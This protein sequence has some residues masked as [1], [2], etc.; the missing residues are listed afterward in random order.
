MAQ[1]KNLIIKLRL[2]SCNVK[3]RRQ[4]PAIDTISCWAVGSG[5]G[6]SQSSLHALGYLG[7]HGRSTP[8]SSDNNPPDH[9]FL[10]TAF[11]GPAMALEGKPL[12]K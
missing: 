12:C 5:E 9:H 1:R 6:T 7:P 10:A 2:K 11:A 8:V 4:P 3:R